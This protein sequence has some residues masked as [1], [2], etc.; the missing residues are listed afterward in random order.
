MDYDWF[1]H[2]YIALF[3]D[4]YGTLIDLCIKVENKDR[5]TIWVRERMEVIDT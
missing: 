4:H 3:V 5:K 2:I 1:W